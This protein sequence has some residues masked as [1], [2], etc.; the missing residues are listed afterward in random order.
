MQSAAEWWKQ[1]SRSHHA[2]LHRQSELSHPCPSFPSSQ[3]PKRVLM[4]VDASPHSDLALAWCL[5]NA[6]TPQ[7][8]KHMLL[9]GQ[10]VGVTNSDVTPHVRRYMPLNG[11]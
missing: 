6:L 9:T 1:A 11:Q 2:G 4:A 5:D 3:A 7:V 10:W 8:G